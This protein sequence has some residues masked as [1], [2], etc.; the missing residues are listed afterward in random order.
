MTD[1][2]IVEDTQAMMMLYDSLVKREGLTTCLAENAQEAIF[3]FAT[4][5]PRV[6]LLDLMLPDRDGLD[7]MDEFLQQDP[8]L[9]IVVIT[10]NGS[11]NKAVEAMRLGAFDFLVKPV[12]DARLMETVRLAVDRAETPVP[13]AR[14]DREQ[15]LAQTLKEDLAIQKLVGLSFDEIERAII[16]ATIDR[17]EGSLPKAADMLKLAPSTL[18]R[19]REAWDK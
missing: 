19:K 9:K 14:S 3:A 1:V 15:T 11:M 6:I 8:N 12:G 5:R 2:M 18:Y 17:C 10:A 4:K 13:E 16:E 7:L